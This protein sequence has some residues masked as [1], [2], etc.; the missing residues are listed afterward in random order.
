MLFRQPALHD[1]VASAVPDAGDP[2]DVGTVQGQPQDSESADEYVRPQRGHEE[3]GGVVDAHG[4]EH[5]EGEDVDLLVAA[6]VVE[7]GGGEEA[8]AIPFLPYRDK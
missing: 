4:D 3:V 2:V 1:L 7:E 6:L 5:D 8:G